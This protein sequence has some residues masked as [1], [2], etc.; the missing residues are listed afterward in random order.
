M[1]SFPHLGNDEFHVACEALIKHARQGISREDA[2]STDMVDWEQVM[3]NGGALPD[4]GLMDK[5]TTFVRVTR[6]VEHERHDTSSHTD[7][8][9]DVANMGE[10]ADESDDEEL[11]RP[12]PY[13]N[14]L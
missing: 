13:L 14:M 8:M 7:G 3:C 11:A 9:I 10:L 2:D 1:R 5:H 12:R 6:R 4:E